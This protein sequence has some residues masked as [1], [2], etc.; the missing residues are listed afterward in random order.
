MKPKTKLP[1]DRLKTKPKEEPQAPPVPCEEC[2]EPI[3]QARLRAVA[4]K[5]CVSCMEM[6]E[7]EEKDRVERGEPSTLRHRM[8]FEIIGSEEVEEVNL[9]LIR[10][11][12]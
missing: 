7:R 3:P 11:R 6:L 1:A 8:A 4:T 5:L 12:G 9:H 2:E 10:A